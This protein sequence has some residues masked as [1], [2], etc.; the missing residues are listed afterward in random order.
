MYE[1]ECV[2]VCVVCTCRA[3]QLASELKSVVVGMKTLYLLYLGPVQ[4][5]AK[6]T[7]PEA[8]RSHAL[9]RHTGT[10]GVCVWVCVCTLLADAC[11]VWEIWSYTPHSSCTK[12]S[13]VDRCAGLRSGGKTKETNAYKLLLLTCMQAW[14]EYRRRLL[15][16]I[17]GVQW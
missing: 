8:E 3:N 13:R 11:L 10:L 15:Y 2:R 7:I 6:E 1:C 5:S 17:L 16:R 14:R 4:G 12:Q 9:Y